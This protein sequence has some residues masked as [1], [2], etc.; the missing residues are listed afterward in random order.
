MPGGSFTTGP[1]PLGC[2]LCEK[3]GKMVLFITGNCHYRCPYCPISSE[4]RNVDMIWA[5]ERKLDPDDV[6]GVI[7]E[8][9]TMRALGTGIAGGDPMFKP[10]R[11][12]QYVRALK[13][14]FGPGHHIHLYTQIDFDPAWLTKLA[15][16]GL[17]EIRFHPPPEY[18]SRMEKGHHHRLIPAAKAT[19]MTVGIEIPALPNREKE[20][21]ALIDY[22]EANGLSYINLNELEFSETNFRNLLN[23][24]YDIRD[25]TSA[26]AK[27]S[28]AASMRL[29][30]LKKG[31]KTAVHYC[32]ACF[33][34]GIQLRN[35]LIRMGETDAKTYEKRTDDGTILKGI[36]EV[37]DPAPVVEILS[38]RFKLP[39][40]LWKVETGFVEVAPWVLEEIARDIPYPCYVSEVYPTSSALEVER[41]PLN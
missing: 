34:D 30:A 28:E 39:E 37:S 36:V 35:R 11:V 38:K 21:S 9:K 6:D 12:V 3:G 18:W 8:A 41:R 31:G 33:K 29:L 4:R 14:A 7:A 19:G 13:T 25:P 22:A 10:E 1:L 32:S 27:E 2:T 24:G 16:A 17:D 26:G 40:T 15:E 5:N 20:M 23:M